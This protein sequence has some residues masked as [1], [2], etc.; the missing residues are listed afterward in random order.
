MSVHI[1]TGRSPQGS[2]DTEISGD[3]SLTIRIIFAD[4]DQL[5]SP[6]SLSSGA[7]RRSDSR[8]DG[9]DDVTDGDDAD[10]LDRAHDGGAAVV[11]ETP[12][13]GVRFCRYRA[14]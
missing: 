7:R 3:R 6:P 10:S 4:P 11:A 5:S 2:A 12:P 14:G 8:E 9:E 1:R 13:P